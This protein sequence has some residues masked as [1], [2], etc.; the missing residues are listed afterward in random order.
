M[1][2]YWVALSKIVTLASLGIRERIQTLNAMPCESSRIYL[3]VMWLGGAENI[4]F[5]D[6]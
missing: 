1:F 4:L 3:R 6:G 2:C 5:T